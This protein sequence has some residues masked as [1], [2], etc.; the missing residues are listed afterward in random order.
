MNSLD[1]PCKYCARGES[2]A[3]LKPGCGYLL[4]QSDIGDGIY[5]LCKDALQPKATTAKEW[6]RRQEEQS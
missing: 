4:H 5:E 6:E 1:L 3:R 2:L